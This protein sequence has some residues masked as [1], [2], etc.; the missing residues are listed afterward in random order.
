VQEARGRAR[1]GRGR[2]RRTGGARAA[3]RAAW[4]RRATGAAAAQVSWRA[5]DGAHAGASA[6]ARRAKA[7]WWR[8]AAAARHRRAGRLGRLRALVQGGTACAGG[9]QRSSTGGSVSRCRRCVER[10][11][12]DGASVRTQERDPSGGEQPGAS[13]GAQ[14]GFRRVS[15]SATRAK[16]ARGSG[17]RGWR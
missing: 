12:A 9:S 14:G 2:R 3:L 11:G 5:Q 16:D 10:A 8:A 4:N 6:C 7:R 13:S 1:A 15:S 17:V